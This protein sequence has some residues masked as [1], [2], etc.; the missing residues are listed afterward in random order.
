MTD[1]LDAYG[2]ALRRALHAE[3]DAVVPAADGLER[4]RARIDERQRRFGWAWFTENWGRPAVAL[5]AAM[6]I[7]AVALLSTPALHAIEGI[8]AGDSKSADTGG[9]DHAVSNGPNIPGQPGQPGQ[10]VPGASTSGGPT[11]SPS[12]QESPRVGTPACAPPP[13]SGP[14]ASSSAAARSA[15]GTCTTPPPVATNPPDTP[16]SEPPEPTPT[17][18]SPVSTTA[19]PPNPMS[20]EEQA[21][22]SGQSGP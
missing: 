16:T 8:T 17:E 20:G 7:A 12:P 13:T 10:S 18:P 6:F 9:P 14:S 19:P 22:Q 2:D 1:P 11:S 3:A 4:I 15:P 5:G 21:P